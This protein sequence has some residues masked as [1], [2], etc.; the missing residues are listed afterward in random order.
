MRYFIELAYKGTAYNGWQRQPN[1][2]S[3]QQTLEEALSR[4][5][6]RATEVVGAGRTDTGVH[7]AFYIAHF[8]TVR[9]IADTA[10]FCYHLNSMLPGDIAISRIYRVA[11]DAHARFDATEREYH[12]HI[13]LGKEPFRRET[14]WQ[15][16]GT[17]DVEAMNR[18]AEYLLAE[19]DFTSF[20]KLNSNNHTN[21]CRVTRAEW[22]WVSG[23]EL[24]FT[25]RADRFLRNMVRAIVGTLVDV[26]RGKITAERFGEIVR[27]RD[28]RLSSSSA[29]AAGLFLA[30]VCYPETI[31]KLKDTTMLDKIKK[32]FESRFG[33]DYH[34]YASAGRV[35][36]IGEHTDY[37]LGFVLPGAID[38]AI[39]VAIRPVEGE[40]ST[41]YS[42]DYDVTLEW[43][44]SGAEKPAEQWACYPYGIVQEMAK[45]GGKVGAFEVVFGGDVPLGAGLSSSAALESA[46]G[47]ALNEEYGL[48]FSREELAK[49]G[50][51]TEHN[52]IGVRCGIM[53]QFASLMG[54]EGKLIRLDCRSLEYTLVPFDPKGCRVVLVDSMVKHSLASSEYNVRREQCE[55][56]VAV[57]A[58]HESGVESLRDVTREMLDK[59]KGEMDEMTY[60]RCAY[61]IDENQRLLDAC[62]ALEAGDYKAFGAKIFG[63][64]DGLSK[65]YG[66]SCKE[67]DFIA[68]IARSTEGVLGARMM[69]GGFGGCVIH[70]L[71]AEAYDGY[72]ANVKAKFAAEF[73]VEPRVIDVVIGDGARR[74][75]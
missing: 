73:G 71:E 21:I 52:Y 31:K 12:Y 11:Y 2:P 32:E 23:R 3:V 19:R 59:Y 63:S 75:Q 47:Y 45:R 69:G 55:K 56:G 37:N 7:A 18:A 24:R 13:L 41:L 48:G 67:L 34:V 6:G 38:K 35:N 36:L 28:L 50:Q 61:V 8:D 62:D 57:V 22:E 27:A 43:N 44:L 68:D 26:G 20:A 60:R 5:L 70:L 53:D 64:H 54:R 29:P 72:I 33:A 4:R 30:D 66:V 40:V 49:I 65:E 39:Y 58:A 46:F 42:V 1:A 14:T 15:Y 9:E 10:D 25:I 16:F 51:M 74:I 17:L